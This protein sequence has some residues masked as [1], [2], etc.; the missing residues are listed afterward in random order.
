MSLVSFD[1][2]DLYEKPLLVLCRPD[3]TQQYILG[4]IINLKYSPRFNALSEL[5]FTAF[6]YINGDDS[7]GTQM[8]YYPYLVNRKIV[9][10]EEFGYFQ[11]TKNEEH[12]DGKKNIRT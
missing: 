3:L 7:D 9:Y 6:E 2:F 5:S 4:N 1:S 10:V 11:I 12:G 8:P